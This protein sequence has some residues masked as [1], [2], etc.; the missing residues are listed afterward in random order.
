MRSLFAKIFISYWLAQALFVALA[1]LV[2]FAA[3]QRDE[4]A[5]SAAHAR[6]LNEAVRVYEQSGT[7][8]VRRY[9]EE[10]RDAEHMRGFLLNEQGED[11]SGRRMPEWAKD[12]ER[13]R[14]RGPGGWWGN[15][16]SPLRVQRQTVMASSGHR[17]SLIVILP[18]SGP[19][20]P[21][22]V[23]GLGI[24]IGIVSSGLVCFLLARYLTAPVVSLRAATQKLAAG[25]LSARASP[26][27]GLRRHDE[28]A[29]LVRD[30]D[31]MAERLEKLVGAQSR[32]LN[33]ISHELRSPLSRLNVALALARKRSGPEAQNALERIDLESNRL[34]GLIERL[35]TV[36]R[37]EGSDDAVRKSA[38]RLEELV[39]EI[40]EDA[41]FE[42]QSRNCH[43]RVHIADDCMVIGSAPLLYSAIE[44]VVRNATRY[45]REG[46]EVEV[47]LEQGS[48]PAGPEAVLRV[49]DSG[50][51][52]PEDALDKLFRPF[53]RIDDARGRQTGGVGLG[54]AIT[55][56]A[57]GL[58]GGT[59]RA[60]NRPQGGLMVEIRLPLAEAQPPK[61]ETTPEVLATADTRRG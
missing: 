4:S 21:N 35:L 32:L 25:D 56:R 19:L 45:T 29:D 6:M 57:V 30:F 2:T 40:A 37:L 7:D 52:V 3:R 9:L 16:I 8:A 43:V 1:I 18:P 31:A 53:Y 58:H 12:A 41:D 26:P 38:V 14:G 24:I 50:P 49:T 34:N 27:E 20:G 46:T 11:I 22:G 42:A 55:E 48:G 51:G 33:D 28:M 10:A 59:V 17:Y 47:R 23:P 5:V 60:A 39:Q 36:A 13:G 44:N 61:H 15:L 54:L